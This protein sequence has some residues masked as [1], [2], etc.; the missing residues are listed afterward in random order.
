MSIDNFKLQR[1]FPWGIAVVAG[2]IVLLGVSALMAYLYLKTGHAI[3]SVAEKVVQKAPE[4][5]QNFKTGKIT[6]TFRESIPHLASTQG[7][8]LELAVARSDETFK[9]SDEK[10]IGWDYI[11]LGT[12]VAEIRAP[13]TFRYHLRLSETWRLA[14]REQVC[15]V[16]A[17]QIRP[18][19]PPAIHTTDMEKRA[20]SGWARFDKNDKL[21]ALEKSM[22]EQL[23]QRAMDSTRLAL[24]RET[25]RQ[26]VAEFVKRWLIREQHWGTNRFTAIGV[27]FPD[28]VAA[29]SDRDLLQL[30]FEP[31][32][33]LN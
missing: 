2:T 9:R 19:L 1:G 20:E 26:S 15:V 4:I 32:V 27:V 31:T 14:S 6:Q 13:V 10:R 3:F 21:D 18:S 22:S 5:A 11:Y 28:E 29:T 8:V 33:R 30:H 25:C 24:V 7:D 23:E 16:L 12:T 17:P